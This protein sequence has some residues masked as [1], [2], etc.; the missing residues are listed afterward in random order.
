MTKLNRLLL[1]AFPDLYFVTQLLIE[2]GKLFK[3][4]EEQNKKRT[5]LFIGPMCLKLFD[6]LQIHC[7]STT[8]EKAN[9]ISVDGITVEMESLKQ[10]APFLLDIVLS[11]KSCEGGKKPHYSMR[12]VAN[13]DIAFE[14]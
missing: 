3:C 2:Q 6:L 13:N 4:E 14:V 1:T 10:R 8:N 11:K 7:R 5:R 12:L 9:T